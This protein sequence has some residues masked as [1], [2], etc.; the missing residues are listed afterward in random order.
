MTFLFWLS[1]FIVGFIT[2]M[3]CT[4]Y[5]HEKDVEEVGPRL[6]KEFL[7]GS[8][9]LGFIAGLF[10]PVVLIFAFVFKFFVKY[11]LNTTKKEDSIE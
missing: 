2:W 1:Y 7:T 11:I 6:A 5:E 3:V 8:L 4:K 10:W 9:V